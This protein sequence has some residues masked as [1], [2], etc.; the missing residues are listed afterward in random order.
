MSIHTKLGILNLHWKNYSVSS[1]VE[2]LVL[3]DGILASKQGVRQ[4][5]K[6]YNK[7]NTIARKSGS[8]L[9]PKLSPAIQ[10]ITNQ[11]MQDDDE[12]AATQLQAKLASFNV[13]VSLAAIVKN[14]IQLGW[15]Y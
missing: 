6:R 2:Y 11:F 7:T 4:F 14:R 10:Q 5:L 3:E 15:T 9:P 12:T 13:Y 8:G 1:I